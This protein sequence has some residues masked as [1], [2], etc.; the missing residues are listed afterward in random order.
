M[1]ITAPRHRC[2]FPDVGMWGLRRPFGIRTDVRT[3]RGCSAKTEIYLRAPS[4][5]SCCA[6]HRRPSWHRRELAASRY[7]QQTARWPLTQL[8]YILHGGRQPGRGARSTSTAGE[9]RTSTWMWEMS[10][11]EGPAYLPRPPS[12]RKEGRKGQDGVGRVLRQGQHVFANHCIY[13][14]SALGGRLLSREELPNSNYC[15]VF[16]ALQT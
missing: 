1:Y 5:E 3:V 7:R 11:A 8:I 13:G 2:S 9:T 6:G 16:F 10:T 15:I 14:D 12:Q 4:Y